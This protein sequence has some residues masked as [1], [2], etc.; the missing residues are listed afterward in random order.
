M[1]DR[2]RARIRSCTMNPGHRPMI[3][4]WN[5]KRTSRTNL[6]VGGSRAG[7]QTYLNFSQRL[8]TFNRSTLANYREASLIT[9]PTTIWAGLE[10]LIPISRVLLVILVSHQFVDSLLAGC[11]C[12][13]DCEAKLLTR[14]PPP[15]ST[16]HIT[17]HRSV[18]I[19]GA[20]TRDFPSLRN[21]ARVAY[22]CT[23]IG[24][25][26]HWVSKSLE[27]TR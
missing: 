5:S 6:L 22:G 25:R 12:W 17:G 10:N 1:W 19:G 24:K 11:G 21:G 27:N 26:P 9:K 23:K 13:D 14:P 16:P 4:Y 7:T 15:R 2:A 20:T 18:T 3:L 8:S